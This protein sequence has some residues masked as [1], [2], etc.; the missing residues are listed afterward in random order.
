V[1]KLNRAFYIIFVPV[2]LVM[3]GYIAVFRAMGLSPG[4]P[5]LVVAMLLFA[6]A[7]WWLARQV[8]RKPSSGRS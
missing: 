6:A 1:G 7:I 8:S 5:R 2:L 3:L 4:Y